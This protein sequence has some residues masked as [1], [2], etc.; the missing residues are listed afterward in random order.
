MN[1][2]LA[3]IILGAEFAAVV[4]LTSGCQ[5]EGGKLL[6]AGRPPQDEMKLLLE[7]LSGGFPCDDFKTVY[8]LNSGYIGV[9]VS[10]LMLHSK[11]N[12]HITV[13]AF[14]SQSP[15]KNIRVS[16]PL[17]AQ[18]RVLNIDPEGYTYNFTGPDK[19]AADSGV[20]AS[21]AIKV[22]DGLALWLSDKK[23]IKV[24]ILSMDNTPCG[25]SVVLEKRTKSTG[26]FRFKAWAE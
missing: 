1:S 4:L 15:A 7:S 8:N 3:F 11:S 17:N 13:Q 9:P 10:L 16:D 5:D 22:E 18:T 24:E 26:A 12:V 23:A 25:K 2:R 21:Y 20:I 19:Q 6:P 14:G